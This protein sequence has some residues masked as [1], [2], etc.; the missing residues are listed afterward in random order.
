MFEICGKIVLLNSIIRQLQRPNFFE[1]E[2]L[3]QFTH[4]LSDTCANKLDI[5]QVWK[6]HD[7]LIQIRI[8]L[9]SRDIDAVDF[10]SLHRSQRARMFIILDEI[11]QV[12]DKV[13]SIC[14]PNETQGLQICEFRFEKHLP[15]KRHTVHLFGKIRKILLRPLELDLSEFDDFYFFTAWPRFL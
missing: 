7:D 5:F 1:P 12:F 9:V 10:E 4:I 3:Q 11:E 13:V 8:C 2:G 6:R 14:A 15:Q